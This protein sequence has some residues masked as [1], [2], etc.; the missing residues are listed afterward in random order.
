MTSYTEQFE[1]I[2]LDLINDINKYP[3][4]FSFG[5][6]ALGVYLF[7]KAYSWYQNIIPKNTI[8]EIGFFTF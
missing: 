4:T 5:V 3:K 7:S 2:K 6:T 8:L 1:K